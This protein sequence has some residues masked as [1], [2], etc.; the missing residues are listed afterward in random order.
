MTSGST[1]MVGSTGAGSIPSPAAGPAGSG[2][3]PTTG[4]TGF[5]SGPSPLPAGPG[6]SYADPPAHSV[7]A[8]A[9]TVGSTSHA[10][11]QARNLI[12][13]A[14]GRAPR[15]PPAA[16]SPSPALAGSAGA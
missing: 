6:P 13:S 10:P 16:P 14:A 3:T 2:S 8:T 12:P 7:F 11:G 4:L 5:G 15:I 1:T 9:G